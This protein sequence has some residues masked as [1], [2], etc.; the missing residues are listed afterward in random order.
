VNRVRMMEK[1]MR[2]LV[3]AVGDFPSPV[4]YGP[5]SARTGLIGY[6]S[7]WGPIR[8]AQELLRRQG[9]PT[10]FYQARTLFPVPEATLAPFLDSVDAAYVIEHNYT[11]QFARLIREHLPDRHGK[12]RSLVKFDG[13]SFRAPE[14]ERRVKEA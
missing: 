1:R 2:K 6:G 13:T 14:I 11:G 8:E 7:T 12:L 4:L 3:Q 9:I 5:E 10:R